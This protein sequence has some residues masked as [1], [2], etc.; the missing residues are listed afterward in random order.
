MRKYYRTVILTHSPLKTCFRFDDYFQ[1]F[2]MNMKGKPYSPYAEHYPN[3]LE[4]TIDYTDSEPE[5]VF[6]LTS[7][8]SNK[9]KE[10]INLLSCLTNHRFFNYDSSVIG[11]GIAFPHALLDEMSQEDRRKIDETKSEWFMGGY[12]YHNLKQDLMIDKFTDVSQDAIFVENRMHEYFTNE[13]IDDKRH[14]L[15]FPNTLCSALHYFYQLSEKTRQKVNSCIYLACDGMDIV[16]TKRSLAFL[17]FVSALEGLVDLDVH[18][19]EILF[20]CGSCKA[21][22]SSLYTCPSCGRPIWGIKQKFVAFLSKFVAGSESSQRIYRDVYNLRSKITHTGKLF[23]SDYELSFEENRRQK[24][25]DDWL[26][27]LKT[28]QLIR[29]SLDSWLRYEGKKKK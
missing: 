16:S 2:P 4:Y 21:I 10:I 11:W 7:I 28:L 18:D 3:Y 17:S 12:I 13:P 24:D 27:R 20:E 26:M 6:T 1:V 25:Y 23:A 9:S 19:D 29:I 15:T 5:D 22:K 14:E 8:K